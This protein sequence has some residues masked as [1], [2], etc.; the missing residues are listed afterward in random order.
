MERLVL[1]LLWY[2][3]YCEFPDPLDHVPC[4]L[5]VTYDFLINESDLLLLYCIFCTILYLIQSAF[6]ALASLASTREEIRMRV[7]GCLLQQVSP[8]T[9][10]L[11]SFMG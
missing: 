6:L 1:L 7:C 10:L 4:L 8:N 5:E 3:L 11:S 9:A 2:V